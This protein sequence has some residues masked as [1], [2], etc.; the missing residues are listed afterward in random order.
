[1]ILMATI[2]PNDN[3]PSD[4]VKYIFPLETFDLAPGGDFETD[5]RNT[6]AAAQSHPWLEV[7]IIQPEELASDRESRS[8][9][10]EEDVLAAPNSI[11]FDGDEVR[12]ARGEQGEISAPRLAVE[13][14]LDQGEAVEHGDVA[15]TLA[16]DETS[17]EDDEPK[18][19]D[20]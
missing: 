13:S 7:E 14:G 16:A 2:R 12:R 6:V 8:V 11:A 15:V 3:A 5:N 4:S 19:G 9:P 20:E 10:Y 1:M 18:E 17:T